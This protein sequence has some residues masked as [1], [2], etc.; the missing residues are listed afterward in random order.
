MKQLFFVVVLTLLG[1]VF[2]CQAQTLKVGHLDQKAILQ[3]IPEWKL[4]EKQFEDYLN[5]KK[6]MLEDKQKSLQAMIADYETRK[7][8]GNLSP[9][10]EEELIVKIQTEEKNFQ[11]LQATA[12]EEVNKKEQELTAPI[13]KRL[14]EA[15][16]AVAREGNYTYIIDVSE[17]FVIYQDPT[18]DVSPLVLEKFKTIK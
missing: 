11:Q 10:L 6:K 9:K 3:N 2:Y 12:Q 7:H 15:L 18:G 17:G 16:K 13:Q 4:A 14:N 8:L 1:S 5:M